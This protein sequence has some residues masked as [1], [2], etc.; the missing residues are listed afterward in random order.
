MTTGKVDFT[1]VQSTMLVTLFL[2]ALDDK[3]KE[4]ILGDHFAA[5]AVQRIGYDWKKLDKA[6]ITRSRASVAQR[7][8]QFDD[9]AADFVRRNPDATVLQLA[10]GLD[11]RAFRLDLPAGVRW[12][13]VDLP[14]VMELRRKL[15]DESDGYRMIAASVTDEAWLEEVPADTPVLIIAEGLVMYLRE[16]EVRQLL[17]QLTD[18][19][20]AGE[21]IFDG[22]APWVAKTTQLLK[23]YLSRWYPYPAYWTAT[24]DGSDIEHWN[25]RLR[26]RENVAVM[27]QLAQSSAPDLRRRVYRAGT[28]F[29][30]LKNYLRVFRAEF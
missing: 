13:D 5:E 24:R 19:F 26:Y 14:D 15:Y 16:N 18:H 12:F 22:M 23:K 10:C 28:G 11:S 9:W 3:E 25:P 1:G 4:P 20:R 6:T 29:D 8:K 27:G 2:R 17:R 7:A 30:W 21:L